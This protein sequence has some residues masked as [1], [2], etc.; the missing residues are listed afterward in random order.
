MSDL[1]IQ[2][3]ICRRVHVRHPIARAVIDIL[4]LLGAG[5]IV[6]GAVSKDRFELDHG[7]YVAGVRSS[8]WG[9]VTERHLIRLQH[10][11]DWEHGRPYREPV[12][13]A[14]W[15]WFFKG[16]KGDWYPMDFAGPPEVDY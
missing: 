8:W 14:E 5:S 6:A 4:A 3:L 13:Y 11:D 12:D 15:D 2:P 9:L 10:F 1:G 16:K 7:G